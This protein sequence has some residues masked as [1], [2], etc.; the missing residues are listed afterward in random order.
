MAHGA[1]SR[2]RGRRSFLPVLATSP[3][4]PSFPE[5][6]STDSF[7]LCACS[8][9]CLALA[10][11]N[12]SSRPFRM[13]M[14][15][16]LRA[17]FSASSS[18]RMFVIAFWASLTSNSQSAFFCAASRASFASRWASSSAVVT[19]GAMTPRFFPLRTSSSVSLSWN[20][21]RSR[22]DQEN[23]R[24]NNAGSSAVRAMAS[25]SSSS[26]GSRVSSSTS[27]SSSHG[28]SR[29]GARSGNT[30]LPVLIGIASGASF[31]S[32]A[33]A[34]SPILASSLRRAASPA[35]SM[36]A[37]IASAALTAFAAE[38]AT[39]LRSS[40][41]TAS[42]GSR[43]S[44]WRKTLRASSDLPWAYSMEAT[45]TAAGS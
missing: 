5:G 29:R 10:S 32:F 12:P 34:I 18:A 7:T 19:F 45:A 24:A 4:P 30:F 8:S 20:I 36:F 17:S 40:R 21:G 37:A 43:A 35:A 9:A 33:R 28:G 26:L 42:W 3:P 44:I 39:L 6:A 2:F 22:S 31:S 15:L 1:G 27:S 11:A 25:A 16:A 23:P 14:T 38:C 13:A 41:A